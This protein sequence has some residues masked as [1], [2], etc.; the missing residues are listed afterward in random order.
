MLKGQSHQHKIKIH[1]VNADSIF[2]QANSNFE[3]EK[4][5]PVGTNPGQLKPIYPEIIG[6]LAL[7]PKCYS[8]LYREDG[9]VKED[10]KISGFQRL[11]VLPDSNI[12]FTSLKNCYNQVVEE[13]VGKFTAIQVR[14]KGE[15]KKANYLNFKEVLISFK[16][17][18]LLKGNLLSLRIIKS[19]L[20]HTA[21]ES[22]K[23]NFSQNPKKKID[24]SIDLLVQGDK[25]KI[26]V[27]RV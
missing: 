13:S 1:M 4:I 17:L 23:T 12:D 16:F 19:Q 8:V 15:K 25:H 20:S 22:I 6:F 11:S 24:P 2:F 9:A 18:C 3:A 26:Y 14:R 10:I 5:L 21:G 27:F 7:A